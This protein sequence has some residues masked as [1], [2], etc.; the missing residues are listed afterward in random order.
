MSSLF[1]RLPAPMSSALISL[2]LVL[3]VFADPATLPFDDCFTGN[4]SAKLSVD[5]VYGQVLTSAQL[6]TY[7]NLTV[8]GNSAQQILEFTDSSS[9]L[10][11]L[12][13]RLGFFL[14]RVAYG[15]I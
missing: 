10:G 14:C 13:P 8:I 6:G 9:S 2:L 12:S 4:V 1:G 7:L 3:P 5:E 11:E 15:L